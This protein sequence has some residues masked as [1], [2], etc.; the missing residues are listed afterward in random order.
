MATDRNKDQ[1]RGDR[2]TTVSGPVQA[3]GGSI[4][5]VGTIGHIKAGDNL[6]AFC[7]NKNDENYFKI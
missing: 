3:G 6:P 7:Y 2:S 1:R 4:D 5:R